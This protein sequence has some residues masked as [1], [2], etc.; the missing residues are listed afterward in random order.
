MGTLAEKLAYTK[1]ARNEITEAIIAKGVDCPRAAP[2]CNFDEY[3]MQIQTG[4]ALPSVNMVNYEYMSTTGS[5][6]HNRT[7]NGTSGNTLL[8]LLMSRGALTVPP[9]GWELI[10]VLKESGDYNAGSVVY[11]QY[12]SIFKKVCTGNESLSYEQEMS[13]LSITCIVELEN[14]GNI[15]I[16][17]NTRQ[18]D[19][20]TPQSLQC[21]SKTSGFNL[22][23]AT[24]VYFLNNVY[25]WQVSD[26][27]VWQLT[28]ENLALRV[29]AFIDTRLAKDDFTI[30]SGITE[31]T[32]RYLSV[33]CL[34]VTPKK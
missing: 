19:V 6:V 30:S 21:S 33:L 10:G 17:E 15:S 2:F 8:M 7:Y 13:N 28:K 34:N 4:G 31:T 14:V 23:V 27:D 1:Q 5:T 20:A 22:W 11:I 3:I 29:A 16:I 26:S 18:E 9:D 25:T 32:S 12:V 24:S